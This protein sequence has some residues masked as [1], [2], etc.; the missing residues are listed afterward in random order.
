MLATMFVAPTVHA[1]SSRAWTGVVTS[2]V[3]GDTVWV[4]RGRATKADQAT[5]SNHST[6]AEDGVDIRI[7]GI[8]APESCQTY[9]ITAKEAL[10][11]L[12]L[13]QKVRVTSHRTDQY[14][15][16]VARLSLGPDDVGE[17]MVR[18]GH[19][20]SYHYRGDKGPYAEQEAAAQRLGR[21]LFAASEAEQPHAFRTRHGSCH[22]K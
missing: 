14:G 6:H 2:V 16:T 22:V 13:R 9:G 7:E 10:T 8:D 15:R 4:K 21:G 18:H 12:V 1:T 17:W 5:R 19:A 20:W 11:K 3:D